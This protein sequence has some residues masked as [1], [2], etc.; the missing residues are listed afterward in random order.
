MRQGFLDGRFLPGNRQ[1][2]G[3]QA[4]EHECLQ[5]RRESTGIADVDHTGE[6]MYVVFGDAWQVLGRDVGTHGLPSQ[7]C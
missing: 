4:F 7:R 2:D 6:A 5:L 1:F 3:P